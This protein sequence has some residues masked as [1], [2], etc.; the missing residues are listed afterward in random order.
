MSRSPDRQAVKA[1]PNSC[2]HSDTT[3]PAI[4]KTNTAAYASG[5]TSSPTK[6]ASVPPNAVRP[7]MAQ[8]IGLGRTD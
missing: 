6:Y 3:Q 4:T 5:P 2:R 7:T 8:K 1:C